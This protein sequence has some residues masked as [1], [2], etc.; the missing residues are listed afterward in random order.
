LR[1]RNENLER[2]IAAKQAE[3]ELL[4]VKNEHLAREVEAKQTRLSASL[5][6][7]AHKN[8]FLNDLLSLL[9]KIDPTAANSKTELRKVMREINQEIKQ[10][11][12]WEQFQFHFDEMHKNFVTKLKTLHPQISSNDQRLCCLVRLDL[13][14]REIASILHITVNGVEQTKYRLKKKMDIAE[15]VT[16]NEYIRG[17]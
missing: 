12:Y 2:E 5:L 4:N 9:Q 17:I 3:Q 10:E 1:L 8:Q 14:N 6:Q 11:D 7:S 13:N 15:K 16:L